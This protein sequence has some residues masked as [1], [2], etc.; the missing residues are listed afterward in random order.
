VASMLSWLCS[1]QRS[2]STGG[3]PTYPAV[4]QL[5]ASSVQT[6]RWHFPQFRME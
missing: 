3:C 5:L 2:F 6:I 1:T 4:A